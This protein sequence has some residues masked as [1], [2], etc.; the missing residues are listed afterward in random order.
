MMKTIA[1]YAGY[2]ISVVFLYLTFRGVD[3]ERL[4][5]NFAYVDVTLLAVAL[6]VN[7]GFLSLR[8]MYQNS[9]LEYLK[10]N[11][12]F[13]DFDYSNRKGPV[14]QR[15]SS[16]ENRRGAKGFFL[17]E[18]TG[19]GKAS[20]FS[21]V[22]IEKFIDLIFFVILFFVIA[23]RLRGSVTDILLTSSCCNCVRWIRSIHL[24][25]IQRRDNANRGRR[26]SGEPLQH[27]W[28]R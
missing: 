7:V 19:L 20:L 2:A 8:A 12:S 25:E 6:I 18:R 13:P 5:D 3:Y 28:N 24:L 1:K 26:D 27:V 10:R 9:N 11:I 16:G 14:L 15:L 23:L 22:V 17:S 21:Y 4:V